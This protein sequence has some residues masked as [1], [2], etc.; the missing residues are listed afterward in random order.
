M[1]TEANLTRFVEAQATDYAQAFAQIKRGERGSRQSHWMGAV[2][3]QLNGLGPGRTPTGYG[4]KDLQEA[5]AYLAHPILGPRLIELSTALVQ[6]VGKTATQLLGT[7]ADSQL[8]ASMTL[9]SLVQPTNPVFQ[10]VLDI[11]FEGLADPRTLAILEQASK[12]SVVV[13][14]KQTNIVSLLLASIYTTRE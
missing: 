5:G 11:Y 10:T 8:Q 4:L 12:A 14:K 3:P 7:P 6:F 13:T 1:K 9:F 2:F